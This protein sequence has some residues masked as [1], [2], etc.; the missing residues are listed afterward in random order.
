MRQPI[1]TEN[2]PPRGVSIATLARN[3]LRGSHIPPH[4]H[5]SDQLIYASR[6]VMQVFSGQ[7]FWVIPPQ[8]GLWIP[9]RIRHSIRMPEAVSLRT[10]YLRRGLTP[11]ARQC[12]VFHV[13]PLLREIVF[14]IVRMGRLRNRDRVERAFRDLLV[15]QLRCA[16][17]VPTEVAMPVDPR[18]LRACEQVIANLADESPLRSICVSAGISVRTL[19]RVFQREVGTDFETWRRQ[20]RLMKAVELLV[21]GSSVKETAYA[22]G[23]QQPN[24]LVALFRTTFGTTP[25]AWLSTLDRSGRAS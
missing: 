12:Q 1:V 17:S 16:R 21:S 13:A 23:Y 4:A 11:L 24:P 25:K 7:R 6:G 9:A 3:Y 14:E 20:M 2:D 5:A 8:F 10:L 22:V 18:A 19:E 15:A